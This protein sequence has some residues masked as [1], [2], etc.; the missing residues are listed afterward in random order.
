YDP[1]LAPACY[2][3]WLRRMGVRYILLPN[4]VLGS[5]G[6]QREGALLRSGRS[7][8]RLVFTNAFGAIWELPRPARIITGP[9]TARITRLDQSRLEGA[10]G[11]AGADALTVRY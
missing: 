2:R 7:G 6:E 11:E 4:T 5:K 8:L 1:R 3:D 9:G 10:G